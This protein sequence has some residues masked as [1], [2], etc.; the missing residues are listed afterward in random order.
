MLA[1]TLVL[2][3]APV[4]IAV[5]GVGCVGMPPALCDSFVDRFVAVASETGKLRVVTQRDIVQ[6]IGLERQRQLLGCGED[7]KS[8]CLAE[9][10]GA[11]GVDSLLSMSLTRSD[12][13][14]VVTARVIRARDGSIWTTATE[15]VEREGELFDKI[16]SIARRFAVALS[17]EPGGAPVA[18][19]RERRG[20]GIVPWVPGVVGLLA[21]GAGVAVFLS[22]SDERGKLLSHTV[23]GQS[24]AD[25]AASG[26]LKEQLGVG[27]MVGGAV[28]VAASVVWLLV[29]RSDS[30]GPVSLAPVPGGAVV[31]FGR[32]L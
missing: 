17:P 12:P 25:A 5:P 31:V 24:A 13:Y 2:T 15:R 23:T 11:L 8:E 1:L 21:A 3:A 16:D 26:R 19:V 28:A 32:A 30:P 14:F 22:A 10:A 18:E 9:L 20:P 29:S 7:G 6:L 27:L 4:S